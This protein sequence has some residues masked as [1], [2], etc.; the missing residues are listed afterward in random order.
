[1]GLSPRHASR[2]KVIEYEESRWYDEDLH[3]FELKGKTELLKGQIS[4]HWREWYGHTK[5]SS[6][7]PRGFV[8]C[9][10]AKRCGEA[11]PIFNG[12]N[13]VADR[14]Q[15]YESLPIRPP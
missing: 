10:Q 14:V 5:H 7:V 12:M 9:F 11:K 1:L 8:D 3:F 4:L 6:S 15:Y 13:L 2:A